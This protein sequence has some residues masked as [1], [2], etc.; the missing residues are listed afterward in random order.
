MA[1]RIYVVENE[2]TIALVRAVSPTK[3]LNHVVKNSYQVRVATP[4]DV[5]SYMKEGGTVDDSTITVGNTEI[6][7]PEL[8]GPESQD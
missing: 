6:P 5:E 1:G 3:A 2:E 7:D 4:D 8:G